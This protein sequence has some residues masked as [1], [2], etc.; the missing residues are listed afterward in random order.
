[1]RN[2]KLKCKTNKFTRLQA[3][4]EHMNDEF[5]LC[6]DDSSMCATPFRSLHSVDTVI[7]GNEVGT[8]DK[9]C[10]PLLFLFN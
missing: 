9:E 1:M 7:D 5:L 3:S 10:S 2:T 8:D 4:D 6:A